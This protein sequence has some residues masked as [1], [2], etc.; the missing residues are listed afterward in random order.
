MN[1]VKEG[2]LIK[3]RAE[4]AMQVVRKAKI[5]L[6][7]LR[8]GAGIKGKLVEAM[9]CGTPS[10]TT[11]LG[12]EGMHGDFEWNGIIANT[13]QEIADAA[14]KLYSDKTLWLRSQ[15]KGIEI[16]N[17]FYLFKCILDYILGVHIH[18]SHRTKI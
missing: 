15:E 1:N 9:Q 3:G 12:S 2:F 4:D 14:V 5:C 11:D 13:P 18:I 16:I 17:N 10:V 8:F 6:A 7:P